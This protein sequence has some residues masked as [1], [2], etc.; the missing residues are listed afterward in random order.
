MVT[1]NFLKYSHQLNKEQELKN[2]KERMEVLLKKEKA[3]EAKITRIS[4]QAQVEGAK[5]WAELAKFQSMDPNLVT[6]PQ[7]KNQE[8]QD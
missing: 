2:V 6:E 1:T 4:Q 7:Q 5:L 3:R 8:L